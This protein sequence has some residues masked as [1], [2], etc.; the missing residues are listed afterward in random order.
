[1]LTAV[2]YLQQAGAWDASA[3]GGCLRLYGPQ[4][5]TA[6][7]S[8]EDEEEEA[9]GVGR[10]RCADAQADIAPVADRLVLF[11][12]DQRCPHEVL[13]VSGYDRY[14]VTVWFFDAVEKRDAAAAT[15]G[16]SSSDN[17]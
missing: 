10:R 5:A 12:A 6:D 17:I 9:V 4:C 8:E 14:A 15:A 2:Y 11:L 1:M 7:S 13:P 3:D 16:S